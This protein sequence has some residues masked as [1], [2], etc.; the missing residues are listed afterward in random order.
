MPCLF[1]EDI[2]SPS[3]F[4]ASATSSDGT[5]SFAASTLQRQITDQ[6]TSLVQGTWGTKSIGHLTSAVD[7]A[8]SYSTRTEVEAFSNKIDPSSDTF[9]K[10]LHT[11]FVRTLLFKTFFIYTR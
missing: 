6:T 8:I 9:N 3:Q 4:N 7:K 1:N 5:S 10:N 2:E 11:K